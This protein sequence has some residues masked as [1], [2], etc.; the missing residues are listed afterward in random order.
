MGGSLP[1]EVD[2]FETTPRL[3]DITLEHH[4]N[5]LPVALPWR[6]LRNFRYDNGGMHYTSCLAYHWRQRSI[7]RLVSPMLILI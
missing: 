5:N 3:T 7:L 2:V 4:A 1:S 6:Q